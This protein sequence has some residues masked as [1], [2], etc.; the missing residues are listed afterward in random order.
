MPDCRII[1]GSERVQEASGK[2][3]Q[4]PVAE[5]RIRFPFKNFFRAE[6]AFRVELCEFLFQAEIVKIVSERPSDQKLHAE[7]MHFSG[8]L[9]FL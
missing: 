6:S 2:P 4:A 3:A 5:P 8:I 9:G 1:S 7:I